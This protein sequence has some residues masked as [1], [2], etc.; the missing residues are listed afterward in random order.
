MITLCH[1]R[2]SFKLCHVRQALAR[3]ASARVGLCILE[4]RVHVIKFNVRKLAYAS[5][6]P[7]GDETSVSEESHG[8]ERESIE[9]SGMRGRRGGRLEQ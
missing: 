7:R 9:A 3:A 5:P 4:L 2:H 8:R 1:V 6:R